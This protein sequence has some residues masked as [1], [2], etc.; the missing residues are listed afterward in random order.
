MLNF[1][2]LDIYR[3]LILYKHRDYKGKIPSNNNL[4]ES[5]IGYCASKSE[6][7]KY[8]INLGFFNHILYRIT[9]S[10]NI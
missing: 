5:K 8:R 7:L 1:T 10:G 9:F 4:S 2:G 3:S 6:K